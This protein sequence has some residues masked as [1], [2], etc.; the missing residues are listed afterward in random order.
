MD[1]RNLAFRVQFEGSESPIIKADKAVDKLKQSVN[2]ASSELK[3]MGKSLKDNT[4]T[5]SI[6]KLDKETKGL[7]NNIKS[8]FSSVSANV[9]YAKG[10][11]DKL[12]KA[13]K[14]GTNTKPISKFSLAFMDAGKKITTVTEK[15]KK[16]LKD[17]SKKIGDTGKNLTKK[18]TTPIVGLGTAGAKMALDLDKGIR[19]V[20]TLADKSILPYEKIKDEVREISD[21]SGI[22]QTEIAEA[23]Y[24]AL[25][26]GVD[27]ANVMKFVRSGID[28]TR[29]GFTDME[30]AIDATTTVLNAYG[31]KAYDISKIHDIFVQTQDKGK[32][33]V[34]EL[35]K[36][37]GRVIPTASSLGVNLNQLGASYAILTAKGQ[38]AQLATTNLNSMLDELGKSGSNADKILR[39][40]TGK[41]FAQLTED[42]KSVG[43]VLGILDEHARKSKQSLKDMFGS[44]T[45]GSAAVILLSEGVEGFNKSLADMDGATGKTAENAKTMEDGW[46]KI[47][48][49]TTQVKN[50]LIDVGVVIA[51]YIEKGAEKVSELV[52]RFNQL[53]DGTKKNI[54]KF[55]GLAAAIGPVLMGASKVISITGG[56]IGIGGKL[57]GGVTTLAGFLGGPLTLI[58]AGVVAGGVALYKNWDKVSAWATKT[59]NRIKQEW[60][61]TKEST[62]RAWNEMKEGIDR[63]IGKIKD[64][65]EGLKDFVKNPIKGTVNIARNIKDKVTG[66]TVADGSHASGLARVPKDNYLANLHKDEEVLTKDDPRNQN[67]NKSPYVPAKEKR[68][69]TV[70]FNPSYSVEIKG[71]ATEKEANELVAKIDKQTR[72]TVQE[73]FYELSLQL[74]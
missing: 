57:V 68:G 26:A 6:K 8:V 13:V 74:S 22:A 50:A 9:K 10:E 58:L 64:G 51:P 24:S 31:D 32:I 14:D 41:G 33:S 29:A 19:K 73:M 11:V 35:G 52:D 62:V 28:L 4:D 49:A 36:N 30:T 20:T 53:D 46:L 48:R 18:I 56:I 43:E 63:A 55:A 3:E 2:G 72:K 70:L 38:N 16:E 23:A 42:G 54:V 15:V 12:G 45:A 59:G 71:S 1:L 27:S 37:I 39:Q 5:K 65:W 61:E 69:F 44:G 66:K 25:S 17:V 47:Q 21:S 40:K 60:Q 34:D 7:K 67:N